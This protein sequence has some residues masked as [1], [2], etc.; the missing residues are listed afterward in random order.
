M[1]ILVTGGTGYI[2]SHCVLEL[3]Q[4]NHT[5]TVISNLVNS[6]TDI[7]GHPISLK[8]IQSFTTK[9]INYK[10]VDLLDLFELE[11]TFESEKFDAVFHLASLKG[12]GESCRDPLKFYYSNIVGSLNLILNLK[13]CCF[14]IC[15][16]YNVKNLIFSSS[17]TVYGTST[18]CL[19]K[20]NDAIGE[21]IT[22]PYGQTKYM[23][24]KM[25]KD[26][27]KS[28]K[29]W[30]II[31]LRYSFMVGAHPSGIIGEDQK[32]VPNNLLP[33]ISQ[34]INGKLPYLTIF[35]NDFN[36]LDGTCVRDYIHVMDTARANLCALNRL[37]EE[38][39]IGFEI[40]NI[41]MGKGYSVM[42]VVKA[43]ENTSGQKIP[44]KI[45]PRRVGDVEYLCCD[46]TLAAKNLK[47]KA[48]FDLD[49]M[50][51]DVVT[52]QKKNPCG[53]GDKEHDSL[54]TG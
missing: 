9:K 51:K 53:Y 21:K 27:A 12:V 25:L 41:G 10:K 19:L 40:Y 20:E 5:V 42:E 28:D 3:L 46:P 38:K 30:N 26:V 47:W 32:G 33:Y 48:L 31:C 49:N 18:H 14:Q 36:T 43:M 35:G 45:M 6:A 13:A 23:I 4:S 8:R 52:W 29:D 54:K 11:E 22:N 17:V 34:V 15:K 16:K 1:H 44:F 2:G 39:N 37:I 24:E 7:E 50:C